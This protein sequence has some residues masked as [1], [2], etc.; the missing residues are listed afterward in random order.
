MQMCDAE[1]LSGALGIKA[2]EGDAAQMKELNCGRIQRQEELGI[3]MAAAGAAA[4]RA[5][6]GEARV[7][8]T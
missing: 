6:P 7:G 5:T 2:D 3:L 1:R 8:G 4:A